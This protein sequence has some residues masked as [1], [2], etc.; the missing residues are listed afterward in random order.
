MS[1]PM[2]SESKITAT[3]ASSGD[4]F[5]DAVE[6]VRVHDSITAPQLATQ[7]RSLDWKLS[8]RT[9]GRILIEVQD[10]LARMDPWALPTP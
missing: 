3:A 10:H 5:A 1:S 8:D 2:T 4:R 7:L 6:I 9:A